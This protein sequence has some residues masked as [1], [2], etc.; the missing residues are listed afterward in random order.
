MAKPDKW[1][2]FEY[3]R[4]MF[5]EL[6]KAADRENLE[7]LKLPRCLRMA[8]AES[9]LLHMR[10]LAELILSLGTHDDDLGLEELL[11]GFTPTGLQELKDRYGTSSENSKPHWIIN[12]LM[13][14]PTLLRESSYDY[15]QVVE[16][17][18]PA[19]MRC[20]DEIDRERARRAS[21]DDP[22]LSTKIQ[23]PGGPTSM[24]GHY[25]TEWGQ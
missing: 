16:V 17:L 8:A 20:L 5:Y 13:A 14:H 3:E 1:A 25:G 24:S 9:L 11:P 10:V 2:T 23:L 15:S 18:A 4:A 19:L 21:A 22:R 6:L 12:K 7:K